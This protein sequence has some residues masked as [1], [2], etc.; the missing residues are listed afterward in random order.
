MYAVSQAEPRRD[1]ILG[2]YPDVAFCSAIDGAPFIDVIGPLRE[3]EAIIRN[4]F[5]RRELPSLDEAQQLETRAEYELNRIQLILDQHSPRHIIANA[6]N[7]ASEHKS[8]LETLLEVL[9]V[10]YYAPAAR[11]LA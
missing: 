7:A 5:Y 2:R 8:A 4:R 10:T 11:M 3:M 1:H 6:R 9:D